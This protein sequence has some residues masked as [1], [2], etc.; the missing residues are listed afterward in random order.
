MYDIPQYKPR[1]RLIKNDR[2][3]FEYEN[4]D[5]FIEAMNYWFVEDHVVTTFKDW[6]E[7]Y[8]RIWSRAGEE[9]IRYIVRDEFGS[10]ITKND[11]L[12]DIRQKNRARR[13]EWCLRRENFIYRHSPVPYTGSRRYR[14]YFKNYYKKPK[15]AQELRW[16]EAYKEFIRGKRTKNWLPTAWEDKARSDIRTRKNWKSSRKT[17]WKE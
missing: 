10:V 7:K 11:I 6:P 17:Q 2:E 13:T 16:N 15:T 4:Y 9:I 8:M 3:V 14:R 12:E 5:E 1:I